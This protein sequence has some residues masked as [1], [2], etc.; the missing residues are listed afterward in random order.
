MVS[1]LLTYAGD[2]RGYAHPLAPDFP[3]DS[4]LTARFHSHIPQLIPAA[5]EISP[6]PSKISSFVILALQTIELSWIGN[7]KRPTRNETESGAGGSP[8]APRPALTIT[9]SS[10]TYNPLKP[11]SSSVP[12]SLSIAWQHGVQQAQ[13]LASVQAPWF[14]HQLCVMPQAIWLRRFR[15]TSN[16]APCTSR[17]AHSYSPPSVPF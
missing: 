15:G 14:H 4:V 2:V 9:L 5:F 1:D 11:S 12:F 7:R 6:L 3:S 17:A 13:F 10:L 8:S 16:G